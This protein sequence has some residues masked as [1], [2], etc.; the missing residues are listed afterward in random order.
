M[1]GESSRTF[2]WESSRKKIRA[3]LIPSTLTIQPFQGHRRAHHSVS[4]FTRGV[5]RCCCMKIPMAWCS[6]ICC[7]SWKAFSEQ[8]HYTSPVTSNLVRPFFHS[9]QDE[10]ERVKASGARVMSMDQIEG[11]EPIH[12]NWGDVDLGEQHDGAMECETLS[13]RLWGVGVQLLSWNPGAQRNLS[14]PFGTY[15]IWDNRRKTILLAVY[16]L[17]VNRSII[18]FTMN[19]WTLGYV[20]EQR[21]R[22]KNASGTSVP[23]SVAHPGITR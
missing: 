2:P 21:N 15:R 7:W 9:Q 3:N 12:E 18:R 14:E 8:L 16:S 5:L 22:W 23:S 4:L 19:C 20:S 6:F 13:K 10:R 17:Q 11:L 1:A